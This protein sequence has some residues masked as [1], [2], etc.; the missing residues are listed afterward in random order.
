[1]IPRKNPSQGTALRP[2]HAALIPLQARLEMPQGIARPEEATL[3]SRE[4]QG[5]DWEG[6]GFMYTEKC[7]DFL[8]K[9]SSSPSYTNSKEKREC[10]LKWNEAVPNTGWALMS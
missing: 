7:E 6:E 9:M 1:M 8:P 5:Q 3:F 4:A 2:Q 10:F